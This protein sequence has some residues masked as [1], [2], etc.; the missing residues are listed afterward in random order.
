M[1]R[2]YFAFIEQRHSAQGAQHLQNDTMVTCQ[3]KAWSC[4]PTTVQ[5]KGGVSYMERQK[6]HNR[7]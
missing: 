3:D 6:V 2:V 7:S 4:G 5:G 1:W